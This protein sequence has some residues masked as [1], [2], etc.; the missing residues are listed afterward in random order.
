[1]LT[2]AQQDEGAGARNA[3]P[4]QQELQVRNSAPEE[5]NV[6]RQ[7]TA[8]AKL[9]LAGISLSVTEQGTYLV[10]CWNL[11]ALLPDLEAVESFLRRVVP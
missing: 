2:A 4:L 3:R 5:T 9:A 11:S 7:A 8:V 10:S 1:M 6:K